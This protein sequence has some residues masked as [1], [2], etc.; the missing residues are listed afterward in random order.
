MAWVRDH[1]SRLERNKAEMDRKL[2]RAMAKSHNFDEMF[3]DSPI[4]KSRS[5]ANNLSR[6]TMPLPRG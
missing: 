5:R 2:K 3:E 6:L 1:Y 4:G